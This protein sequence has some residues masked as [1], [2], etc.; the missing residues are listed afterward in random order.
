MRAGVQLGQVEVDVV[1]CM[2]HVIT[3]DMCP[4]ELQR[5][6]AEPDFRPMNTT[7][8]ASLVSIFNMKA[9][10]IFLFKQ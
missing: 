4:N 10:Q 8:P 9:H 3:H 5:T 7:G 2:Q 1:A 6:L